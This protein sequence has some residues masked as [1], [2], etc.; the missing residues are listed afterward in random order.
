M[1]YSVTQLSQ[2]TA[3]PTVGGT[4]QITGDTLESIDVGSTTLRT[5]GQTLGGILIAAIHT[6]VAVVVYTAIADVVLVH[7]VYDIHDSLWVVSGITVN[8][9]IEDVT[10]TGQ[11]VIWSLDLS[12][13]LDGALVVNRHVVRVGIVCLVC[14]ALDLA[15]TLLVDTGEAAREALSWGSEDGIVV[16]IAVAELVGLLLHGADDTETELLSLVALAVVLATEGNQTLCQADESDTERTLVDDWCDG[17]VW[18]EG[19]GTVPEA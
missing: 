13:V 16:L 18:T 9:H 15:E 5:Y 19:R 17:V 4:Y 7:Q 14:H 10:A 12:L 11:V 1:N 8:L 2:L 3:V 6:A